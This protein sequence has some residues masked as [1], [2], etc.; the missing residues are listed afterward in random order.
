MAI[1][2]PVDIK[3]RIAEIA[4]ETSSKRF[5]DQELGEREE[6]ATRYA[7]ENEKHFVDYCYDNIRV[8]TSSMTEVRAAQ[9]EC[10]AVYEEREPDS[11]SDKEFWQTKA[12]IP[13]PHSAVQ[14]AMSTIKKAFPSNF[15]T[16][17][18]ETR[19]S[20]AEFW[21]TLL[22]HYLG[23][24]RANFGLKFSDATGMGFAIG[25]SLE[26]IPRWD[27]KTGLSIVLVEP[28][29][30]HR[31][32]EAIPREPQSGLYWIHQEFLDLFVLKK[33]EELGRYTNISK[34]SDFCS[35]NPTENKDL[36]E[37]EIARRKQMIWTKSSFRKSVLT[38]EFWG[39]ILDSRGD[40]LLPDATYTIAGVNVIKIPKR[41]PFKSMRW[42]GTSFSP[43]PHFTRYEGRGLLNG[44][45]SIWYLM[46]NLLCLHADNLNWA[47][48][49]MT[50]IVLNSLVDQ[51][52]IDSYPGKQVLVK[53]SING[54]QVIRDVGSRSSTN[55]ALAN[56][57]FFDQSFQ[58]GSYVTD[59]VQ[60]LPGYRKEITL[61]EFENNLSQALGV[62]SLIG[63][64]LESAAIW[65]IKAASETIR[66][67]V[68]FKELL[69]IFDPEV[70]TALYDS[71]SPNKVGLP[72]LSGA[73]SVGGLSS[74]TREKE[75]LRAIF[76]Y[77]LPLFD[78]DV[79]KPY[80]KPYE[81]LSAIIEKSDLKAEGLIIKP[82]K[83]MP[84]DDAQ[85][86]VQ[87]ENIG[88]DD[89]RAMEEHEAKLANFDVQ[90]MAAQNKLREVG[91]ARV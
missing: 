80:L 20:Y 21:K 43:L 52:D 17:D 74:V 15:F 18:S 62:F 31:D 66:L 54:Q 61:G 78:N 11:F 35:N 14:Y 73:I 83:A 2:D 36:T 30:I 34:V 69:E 57:Q 29:K 1:I 91:N 28:W 90:K 33:S 19:P 59:A 72:P 13:K 39:T 22:G 4:S 67:N 85:Q 46:N 16:I 82:E 26:I 41:T 6:A 10:L 88:S 53:E 24:D 56:L 68:G 64:T 8:S 44:V 89:A 38:S 63:D 81:V 7:G 42:P 51:D 84:I 70:V 49:P 55:E 37:E 47:V 45:L 87:E 3:K 50:E 12:T 71:Q 77:I 9:K 76:N 23:R 60:G 32:P 58:R 48:N 25:Q 40:L 79:F 5:D 75:I 27:S 65:V 86:G